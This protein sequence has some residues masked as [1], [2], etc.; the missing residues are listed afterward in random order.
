MTIG[1]MMSSYPENPVHELILFI[2]AGG[3]KVKGSKSLRSTAYLS[4]KGKI[5]GISPFSWALD[6]WG[7]VSLEF[8]SILENMVRLG[9]VHRGIDFKESEPIH[10]P[11]S[12]YTLGL[13]H[14]VHMLETLNEEERNAI[15]EYIPHAIA[16]LHLPPRYSVNRASYE[17]RHTKNTSIN[18]G[19][20]TVNYDQLLSEVKHP[21]NHF[22]ENF[23]RAIYRFYKISGYKAALSKEKDHFVISIGIPGKVACSRYK[24]LLINTKG[25]DNDFKNSVVREDF[26]RS[27]TLHVLKEE[28]IVS[29]KDVKTTM[30][31]IKEEKFTDHAVSEMMKLLYDNMRELHDLFEATYSSENGTLKMI[32][33]KDRSKLD[34]SQVKDAVKIWRPEYYLQFWHLLQ[35]YELR[36]AFQIFTVDSLQDRLRYNG[37]ME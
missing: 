3:A 19:L 34:A 29:E 31:S 33:G 35:P 36:D 20:S 27:Y 18:G 7:P 12:L 15:R 8:N 14:F 1:E 24:Y 32:I 17:W 9:I 26:K 37:H 4:K 28:K 23:I 2:G 22:D 30:E 11:Y 16:W 25:I 13:S 6:F 21:P 10:H 5:S